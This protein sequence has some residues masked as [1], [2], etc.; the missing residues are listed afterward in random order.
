M[1]NAI[2]TR[3]IVSTAYEAELPDGR[4]IDLPLEAADFIDPFLSDDGTTFRYAS[5]Y[6]AGW[7]DWEWPEGVEFVQGNPRNVNYCDDPEVWVEDVNSDPNLDL[8]VVDV[9]EHGNILYSLSGGGPQCEFDTA[10]GGAAI[11][12]PTGPEGYTNPEEAARAIL[13]EYTAWCNG[14]TY[15][16]VELALDP[17]TGEPVG[18]YDAVYGIFGWEQAEACCKT[19]V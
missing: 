9:Y 3:T 8:F 2:R 6:D 4:V 12:I 17:A 15:A 10:R 5:H 11:A 1:S 14:E 13:S 7:G 19:G 16:I 18:D